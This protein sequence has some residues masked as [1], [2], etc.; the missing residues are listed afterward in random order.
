MFLHSDILQSDILYN[1]LPHVDLE[2]IGKL[3]CVNKFVNKLCSDKHFWKQKFK[4]CNKTLP[5]KSDDWLLE[6]KNV[7]ICTKRAIKFVDHFIKISNTNFN[8]Y[9]IYIHDTVNGAHLFWIPPKTRSR[10]KKEYISHSLIFEIYTI[11]EN[12]DFIFNLKLRSYKTVSKRSQ[13]IYSKST[14]LP[15]KKFVKYIITLYYFY[16]NL[17]MTNSEGGEFLFLGDSVIG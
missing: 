7:W 17:I 1:I 9:K 12:G 13:K 14:K 4:I 16:N 8:S 11:S 10:I 2:T 3:L 5:S 15:Y 6:Y